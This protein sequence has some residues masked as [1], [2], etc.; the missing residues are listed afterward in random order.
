MYVYINYDKDTLKVLGSYG[1]EENTPE[2]YTPISIDDWHNAL[3]YGIDNITVSNDRK[4]LI[5]SDDI[6]SAHDNEI[7]NA[8][9]KSQLESIDTKSLRAVRSVLVAM[10]SCETPSAGDVAK[11]A[12]Y[13]AEAAELRSKLK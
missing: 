13:E 11:L 1:E 4:H 8:S 7:S 9:I 2:P 12:E 5:V 3:K 10:H 6:I